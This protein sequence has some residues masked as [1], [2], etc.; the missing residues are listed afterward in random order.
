MG[1]KLLGIG[2]EA[3]TWSGDVNSEHNSQFLADPY[4]FSHITHGILLYGLAWLMVRRLPVSTRALMV[5]AIEAAWEV[6][7]NTDFVINRYRAATISLH[8]YG[9][10]VMNS[11]SD[12][13]FCM[14]GF[15]LASLLPTRTTIVLVIALELMLALWIHDNFT[16]NVIMLIHSFASIR[17]WQGSA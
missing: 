17:A 5:L 13:G 16:L 9:D 3:G 15:T 12:I 10:S 2:G 4:S 1:R 8:Y 14:I 6:V 7:E 11:M